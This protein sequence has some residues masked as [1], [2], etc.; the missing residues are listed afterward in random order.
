MAGSQEEQM[1][2]GNTITDKQNLR[3]KL[4]KDRK[5]DTLKG[6][7]NHL[8]NQAQW[9]I[10]NTHV[11]WSHDVLYSASQ[12]DGQIIYRGIVTISQ[13]H[14]YNTFDASQN[15]PFVTIRKKETYSRETLQKYK[16]G[17]RCKTK[18]QYNGTIITWY[19]R[20]VWRTNKLTYQA[21]TYAAVW[22][23]SIWLF[24]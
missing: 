7:L 16:R 19:D 2:E 5:T 15:S 3:D 18:E 9:G 11:E 12:R 13:N 17:P 23:S 6:I 4:S 24:C 20:A 14:S 10:S 1:C 21:N 22:I 8:E